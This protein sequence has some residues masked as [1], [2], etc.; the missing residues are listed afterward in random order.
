VG[1][2]GVAYHCK[3]RLGRRIEK[4]HKIRTGSGSRVR[5]LPGRE[6]PK[7]IPTPIENENV[8][9]SLIRAYMARV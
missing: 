6:A 9:K 1:V 7:T 2:N 4:A 5:Q 3:S 8:F